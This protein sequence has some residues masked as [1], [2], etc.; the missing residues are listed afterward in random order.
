M[1]K[2]GTRPSDNSRGLK[3]KPSRRGEP[4]THAL[5]PTSRPIKPLLAFVVC[6][7]QGVVDSLLMWFLITFS[8]FKT[9]CFLFMCVYHFDVNLL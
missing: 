6:S 5:V 1:S 3:Y 7:K 8:P 9:D 2:L 4:N